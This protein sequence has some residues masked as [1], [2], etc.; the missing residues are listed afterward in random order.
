MHALYNPIWT[1]DR[2]GFIRS[3]DQ[4]TIDE[5]ER[6]PDLLRAIEQSV[7]SSYLR[8]DRDPSLDV[9]FAYA[10]LRPATVLFV[11]PVLSRTTRP[12]W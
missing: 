9:A 3:L 4:V 7:D 11:L 1:E 12:F 2:T 5:V 8:I 10:A 6:A